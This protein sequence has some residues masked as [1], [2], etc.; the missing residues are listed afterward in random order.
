M[1]RTILRKRSIHTGLVGSQCLHFIQYMDMTHKISV[2]AWRI[3]DHLWS[4]DS[5]WRN[6]T[7]TYL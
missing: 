7:I 1:A 6:L 3:I 2:V 5:N 4:I